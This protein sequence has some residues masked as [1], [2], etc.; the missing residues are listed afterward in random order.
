MATEFYYKSEFL[1]DQNSYEIKSMPVYYA[2]F[3]LKS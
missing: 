1:R 3:L 2:K